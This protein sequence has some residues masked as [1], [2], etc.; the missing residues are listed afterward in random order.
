MTITTI[1]CDI[2]RNT[3]DKNLSRSLF[4]AHKLELGLYNNEE[5]EDE[6]I[7]LADICL[8]CSNKLSRFIAS[9]ATL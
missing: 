1:K 8:D 4:N 2:C 5:G 6:Y 7:D 9:L 3:T